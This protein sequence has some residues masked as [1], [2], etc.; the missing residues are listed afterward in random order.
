MVEPQRGQS[1]E[2]AHPTRGRFETGS[3]SESESESSPSGLRL[4][5]RLAVSPFCEASASRP[6]C[7]FILCLNRRLNRDFGAGLLSP[8]FAPSSRPDAPPSSAFLASSLSSA[9]D[10]TRAMREA[11]LVPS[12][13]LPLFEPRAQGGLVA[14][15]RCPQLLVPMGKLAI[16]VMALPLR[17]GSA[18]AGLA[19]VRHVLQLL[20]VVSECTC[21]AVLTPPI[22]VEVAELGLLHLL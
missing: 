20:L 12:L 3:S 8:E 16:G 7:F 21:R 14:E 13:A 6:A 19:Q 2:D 15:V 18:D 22:L 11:A 9:A 17:E 10:I 1:A 4:W 5:L